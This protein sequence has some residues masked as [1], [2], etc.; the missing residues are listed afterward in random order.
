MW[1][2]AVLYA[3]LGPAVLR[4][5]APV[6]V[7][8]PPPTHRLGGPFDEQILAERSLRAARSTLAG[9]LV[10][11]APPHCPADLLHA[12]ALEQQQAEERRGG[13]TWSSCTRCRPGVCARGASCPW[14]AGCR[15]CSPPSSRA[16]RRGWS[17]G[18]EATC[19]GAGGRSSERTSSTAAR[20]GSCAAL[21][22]LQTAHIPSQL[23]QKAP[24][25]SDGGRS[26]WRGEAAL[27]SLPVPH[28]PHCQAAA[29][30]RLPSFQVA[31][32][33]S[34]RARS[35]STR[36][37]ARLLSS[38][39]LA[40]SSRVLAMSTSPSGRTTLW[41]R[42]AGK[43]LCS[44]FFPAHPPASHARRYRDPLPHPGLALAQ[45]QGGDQ[46]L[47]DRRR[48]V[49]LRRRAQGPAARAE[50]RPRPVRARGA[51]DCTR[52]PVRAQRSPQGDSRPAQGGGRRHPP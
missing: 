38:C 22:C 19:P 10:G 34:G 25:K 43:L 49:A 15:P 52:R 27:G 14:R 51:C 40:R 4:P 7:V 23:Q 36:R 12:P 2:A 11:L 31:A 8:R 28:Q 48:Q 30:A 42:M 17:V 41:R 33:A 39:A 18:D 16:S 37:L 5:A 26:S 1:S 46:R 35:T 29:A 21:L 45:G 3:A 47:L 50:W 6:V 13:L 9:P 24:Q 20:V 44:S 32:R